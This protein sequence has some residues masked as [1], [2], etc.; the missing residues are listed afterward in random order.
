MRQDVKGDLVRINFLRHRFAG[1][2]LLDLALQFFDGLGARAGN[3]LVAGGENALHTES[4]VQRIERH[5]RNGG[6]AV[7]VG[8]DA[9]VLLHVRGI[10]FGH[11]ERDGIVHAEGAGVIHHH[12][13]GLGGDRGE[14]LGD[15]A[16]G[17]EQGDVDAL[18]RVFSEFLNRNVLPS[19]LQLLAD[20]TGGGE[21]SQLPTGK[22]RFSSVL[23]ISMPTAPVAPTTGYM[24]ITVHKSGR[25]TRRR[26]GL[27]S[28]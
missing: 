8:D 4:L 11:D 28:K 2:D 27:E 24:R 17:A 20:G 9:L 13:A 3:G 18:E 26:V 5:Q 16:A 15:A 22:L 25:A 6:G 19:E 1:D 12:A 21:Q 10:D 23:I 14:F 7:R